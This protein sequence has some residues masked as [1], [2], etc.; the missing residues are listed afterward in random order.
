MDKLVH[1]N[2]SIGDDKGFVSMRYENVPKPFR[3]GD[4]VFPDDC[5]LTL[6]IKDKLCAFADS[7]FRKYEIIGE[8]IVDFHTNLQ[9]DLTLNVDTLEKAL[10]VYRDDISKP[11]Q[12]RVITRTYDVKNTT[13][14]D[15]VNTVETNGTSSNE[16]TD[17]EIPYDN[18]NPQGTTKT[19]GTGT[20]GTKG[21]NSTTRNGEN[22]RTGTEKEEWSDVGVAPNYTLL[23]GFLDNNRTYYYIFVSFFENDFTLT[24]VYYD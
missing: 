14:G 22:A 24:E 1:F 10:E 21:K 4:L 16:T 18:S 6:A 23:N 12:S 8:T 19:V 7:Y 11:T 13:K 9:I 5:P 20:N 3:F 17:Y 2:P 15:D